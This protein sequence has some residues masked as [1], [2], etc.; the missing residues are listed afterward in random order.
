MADTETQAKIDAIDAALAEG[1]TTVSYG[2]TT[3]TYDLAT[4]VAERRRLQSLLTE[5]P[6]PRPVSFGVYLGGF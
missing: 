6:N 3:T 4:L 1:V 2:G 5:T